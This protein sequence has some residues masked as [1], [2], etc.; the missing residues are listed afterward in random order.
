MSPS[1]EVRENREFAAEMKFLVTRPVAEQIRDWARNCLA[2]DPNSSAD[3]GDGYQITSIYFDTE[4]YDVFHR[5]GSFGRS[6]YRIR[7]YGQSETVFLERKLK[8]RG[9][10]SKRRSVSGL[11]DLQRL[12][13]PIADRG[14]SGFWF[15]HRLLGRKLRPNCQIS[16]RRTARVSMTANGPVR[17]TL[18]DGIHALPACGTTF[19]GPSNAGT[20][21]SESQVILELKYRMEMPALF[22]G[23]L[24][25]FTLNA[26]PVSKYRLAAAALGYV[27]EPAATAEESSESAGST[28]WMSS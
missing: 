8:T 11:D 25:E 4:K 20:F 5:N 18:D 12:I 26:V 21:L 7:R 28:Q 1:T 27:T 9:L 17:L 19:V 3:I 16:Y 10:V 14:W 13:E 15:H 6:K 22:K 24:Q 2:P 23:L